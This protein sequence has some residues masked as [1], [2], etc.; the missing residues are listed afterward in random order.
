MASFDLSILPTG[1]TPDPEL[2]VGIRD[3]E[4][5]NSRAHPLHGYVLPAIVEAVCR[6]AKRPPGS[7]NY[8]EYVECRH[9]AS[10][11]SAASRLIESL[12]QQDGPPARDPPLRRPMHT[13]WV[14][15]HPEEAIRVWM[16]HALIGTHHE[17][18]RSITWNDHNHW[19]DRS[20]WYQQGNSVKP[21][22]ILPNLEEITLRYVANDINNPLV[23]FVRTH[24]EH[25]P[26]TLCRL[27]LGEGMTDEKKPTIHGMIRALGGQLR[28]L[29]FPAP[30]NALY[31]ICDEITHPELLLSLSI[32]GSPKDMDEFIAQCTRLENLY[33]INH[34]SKLFDRA[35][36]RVMSGNE[37]GDGLEQWPIFNL[38]NL[39]ISSNR[40]ASET[41]MCLIAAT[42]AYSRTMRTLVASSSTISFGYEM[43]FLVW[44]SPV[45]L[46]P[47]ASTDFS[48]ITTTTNPPP[49]PG[50]ATSMQ[51]TETTT[52]TEC[53]PLRYDMY[54]ACF[55]P[56]TVQV[57]QAARLDHLRKISLEGLCSLQFALWSLAACPGLES[58]TLNLMGCKPSLRK[59]IFQ[60]HRQWL[61]RVGNWSLCCVPNLRE[62]RILGPWPIQSRTLV[63][64]L[65]SRQI[66]AVAHH[67]HSMANSTSIVTTTT[68]HGRSAGD[69]NREGKNQPTL[70]RLRILD[71]TECRGFSI[72]ALRKAVR[73][74]PSLK[75]VKAALHPRSQDLLEQWIEKVGKDVHVNVDFRCL[76]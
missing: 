57:H 68:I 46:G 58:L 74:L 39:R 11:D 20:F 38:K 27:N 26:H 22:L 28:H 6:L 37:D 64:M 61:G 36:E 34:R 4:D 29:H 41:T 16:E 65:T 63:R 52:T 35:V 54:S 47:T 24:S 2:N 9:A 42:K 51:P 55:R 33:I 43:A 30:V 60:R 50:T 13:K 17:V 44:A 7:I 19:P 40:G 73:R 18:V 49:R 76:E 10:I 48:A 21:R 45:G 1:L 56:I 67:Q 25:Y 8:L 14:N 75:V 53:S 69:G 5:P 12:Q 72:K 32:G 59:A 31:K 3:S 23:D 15:H 70:P 62:L 71:L 66:R